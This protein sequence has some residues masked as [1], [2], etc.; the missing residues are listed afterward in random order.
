MGSIK[1]MDQIKSILRTYVSTRSIKATCR[2]MQVSRNTVKTYLRLALQRSGDLN[3]V[4]ALP[5]EELRDVF[6]PARDLPQITRATAFEVK[7]DYW[8]K[9][10]RRVGVTRHLLWQEYRQE[11]PAGYG[12]S[13]FCVHLNR[14]IGRRDL[15]LAIAHSPGEKMQIDFAGK[16]LSWVD[17]GTGEVHTC[18]VLVAV[19][20]LSQYTFAIALPSQ[21]TADFVYGISAAVRFYGRC[22]KVILS[23]NLKAFVIKANRYDPDF[24]DVCVQLATHYGVDL[25][26]ARAAKP[27]DKASVENAVGIA[28][29]R[30]YAPLRERTFH[31]I[32]SINKALVEQLNIHNQIPFQKKDGSRSEL[33]RTLEYPL[34]KALPTHDFT[35]TTTIHAKVQN[36]YHVFLGQ[37]K[38]YYSVPYQYVGKQ[39]TVLYSCRTVEV[40]IGQDRVATHAR[41]PAGNRYA[42]QTDVAHMPTNHRQWR[43]A[44]GY[45]AAYFI[46]QA[47]KVG[48]ATAWAVGLI[49]RSRIH[50]PQAYCSCLGTLR[51]AKT[52][53]H[54]RLENAAL[55]CQPAGR[56]TYTMLRNILNRGLDQ[57]PSAI[58]LFSPPRHENIRGEKA[59]Q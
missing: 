1:R 24:N 3:V 13:Q 52:Y 18:Q 5:D 9:E 2:T 42:Y 32:E 16:P 57:S 51:L 38:N 46:A 39:A 43:Q 36:N 33:F 34:M 21:Q 31:S 27:K 22:P 6:Y 4:L 49:L 55:R 29:R 25:Q 47:Q 41:L 53:G 26:A 35:L 20:P 37:C 17:P 59:Y 48:P 23:D 50:E 19:M 10:L 45:N 44:D 7:V 14:A 15:T 8:I 11:H 28:Y 30:L 58:D 56:A 12:Y 54:E 40:Y